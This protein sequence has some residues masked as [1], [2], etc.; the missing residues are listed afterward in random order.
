MDTTRPA[1][2]D[3]VIFDL[4][5]L[6]LNT[7]DVFSMAGKE[8]LVRRG[9]QM[10]DVIHKSMLGR[11][12]DEAFQALKD[13]TGIPDSIEELKLETYELF[14]VFAENHLDTM[15]GLLEL[16]D[17]I[18]SVDIP[19]AVATSS[20]R[21]YMQE[22]LGRFN[23]LHRF[24]FALTADR[25]NTA[26]E[27]AGNTVSS[28]PGSSASSVANRTSYSSP[29]IEKAT[30]E[31]EPLIRTTRSPFPSTSRKVLDSRQ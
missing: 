25:R 26:I 7:E 30:S 22:M 15:P 21:D 19:K 27:S 3:A 31:C 8:L 17:L 11:R 1:D 16:L 6:M 24:S 28:A 20:P 5:G 29:D 13:H 9:M 12:P 23:L 14:Q 4:D 10:T 2:I 18:E